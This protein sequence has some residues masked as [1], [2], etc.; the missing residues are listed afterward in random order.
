MSDFNSSFCFCRSSQSLR[1]RSLWCTGAFSA[2]PRRLGSRRRA[3]VHI[4]RCH[5][6]NPRLFMFGIQIPSCPFRLVCGFP[7][8]TGPKRAPQDVGGDVGE[9]QAAALQAALSNDPDQRASSQRDWQWMVEGFVTIWD[10]ECGGMSSLLGH[11]LRNPKSASFRETTGQDQSKSFQPSNCSQ[12]IQLGLSFFWTSSKDLK[13]M[14]FGTHSCASLSSF[15]FLGAILG[16]SG[17]LR[18]NRQVVRL[19]LKR[20]G[21]VGDLD[22]TNLPWWY[23]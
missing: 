13:S 17:A 19:G 12:P 1:N 21:R 23:H 18:K 22:Q 20:R 9:A 4:R 11:L 16:C 5:A 7:K 14:W 15:A 8:W 10:M 3:E 6:R 2:R